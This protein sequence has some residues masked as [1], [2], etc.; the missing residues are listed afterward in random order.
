M[1]HY[2]HENC[3]VRSIA[4]GIEE[5]RIQEVLQIVGLTNTGKKRTGQFSMGMKQRLGIALALLS[6]PKLLILYEPTNGLDPIAI[7]EL[8]ELIRGFSQQGTTVCLL[9]F[10]LKS[11]ILQIILE[12]LHQ[13]I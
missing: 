3:R 1:H 12:S 11:N 10:Y 9:I 5:E 6:N 2:I 4:L 7:K 8:R 13:D